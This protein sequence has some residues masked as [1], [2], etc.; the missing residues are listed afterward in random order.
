MIASLEMTKA[1][2][3]KLCVTALFGV[4]AVILTNGVRSPVVAIIIAVVVNL[5]VYIAY[6]LGRSAVRDG[7]R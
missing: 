5:C 4:V 6:A 3:T 7:W 2:A 1:T